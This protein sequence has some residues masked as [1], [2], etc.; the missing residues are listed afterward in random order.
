MIEYPVEEVTLR[1]R[2]SQSNESHQAQ[3][4]FTLSHDSTEC[5]VVF[6]HLETM[7]KM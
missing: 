5:D 7:E 2:S 1:H 4:K 6:M 3:K